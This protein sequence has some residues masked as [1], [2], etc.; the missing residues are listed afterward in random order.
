MNIWDGLSREEAVVLTN[1]LE[2][3]W[4]NQVIGDFLG[5]RE[6]GDIWRFSDD[7]DAIRPLIPR[8]AAV[9]K[10]MVE[11]ELVELV[12]TAHYLDWPNTPSLT[13][14]E[15]DTALADLDRW[16]PPEQCRPDHADLRRGK[17]TA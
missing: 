6:P 16:L 10:D 15:V 11:R 9:V 12:F 7:V 3:A 13:T 4:L 8:F 17:P 5:H 14:A 1:A 2:E